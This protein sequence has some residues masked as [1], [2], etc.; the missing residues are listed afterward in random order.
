MARAFNAKVRQREFYPGN[1][2]L[3]KVLHIALDFRGKFAN[4]YDGPFVVRE[5]F[6]GEAIILSDMDGTENALPVNAD[7]LKKYYP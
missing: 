7:A 4:K 2:V 5:V 1:L 3:R 6:S